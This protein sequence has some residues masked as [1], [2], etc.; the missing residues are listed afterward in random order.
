MND[1]G[2]A[3]FKKEKRKSLIEVSLFVWIIQLW[4]YKS[5]Y[6][7]LV[8]QDLSHLVSKKM[9]QDEDEDDETSSTFQRPAIAAEASLRTLSTFSSSA[10]AFLSS[11]AF[12]FFWSCFFQTWD[13]GKFHHGTFLPSFFLS[14]FGLVA[15][16]FF[17]FFSSWDLS[18]IL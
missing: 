3:P 4:T 11:E 13:L 6:Q 14:L 16:P 2:Q 8:S 18:V 9:R 15:L 10:W 12:F 7:V 17:L 1:G 5:I